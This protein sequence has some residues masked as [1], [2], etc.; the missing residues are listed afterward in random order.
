[1]TAIMRSAHP[2]ALWPG[3]FEWFGLSYKEQPETYKELFDVNKSSKHMEVIAESTQFGLAPLKAEGSPI[4]YDEARE[5]IKSTFTHSAYALGYIVTREEM[6]DNQYD[7]LSRARARALAFSMRKTKETVC[8]NVLNRAFNSS[9]LG[10]DGVVL[11]STAHVTRSGNQ[12]NRPT[13]D[14]DLSEASLED[15]CKDIVNMKN[16]RGLRIQAT[17]K[18]LVIPVNEMFNAERYLN[19]TLRPGTG[20]N[21]TNAIKSMGIL[22]EDPLVSPYLTDNDAWFIT[23]DIGGDKGLKLFERRAMDF[24]KDE[25]FGTENAR[26]KS[27][28]RFSTG[29][30][31][32]R[33][34]WGTQGAG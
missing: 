21:D 24:S 2:D 7:A 9:Y 11:C 25:D 23:V 5:G 14:A 15:A 31:D 27:T 32:F 30:S 20:N 18:R 29:W 13:T 10:G 6:E 3:V 33:A 26:A 28:M 22:R 4:T 34:I 12:A 8:W 16:A 1:M 19:S 17:P